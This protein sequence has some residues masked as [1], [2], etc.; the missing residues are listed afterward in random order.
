MKRLFLLIGLLLLGASAPAHAQ[1]TPCGV[2]FNPV[3]GVN[4]A[5][6]RQNTYVGQIL[7]LVPV[8]GA[9]DVWCIDASATKSISIRRLELSGVAT[10]A[11]QVPVTFIRRNTVD[12]GTAGT[13]NITANNTGNPTSTATLVSYTANPTITDTT[14]H[15]T[16]RAGYLLLGTAAVPTGFPIAWNFGT[17]VDGY[18]Q[19]ADLTKGTTQ[20][21][22][23]NLGATALGGGQ[24]LE[25]YVEWT[26]Q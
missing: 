13:P 9:T 6:I 1:N 10:A 24:L 5:N 8:T 2:N 18:N 21:F 15:Q 23:I 22:C 16:I 14:S 4:C 3:I 12:T 26:E 11:T 7:G 20:Q 19:G 17:A 25:G